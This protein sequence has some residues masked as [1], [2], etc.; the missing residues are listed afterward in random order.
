MKEAEVDRAY[1]EADGITAE[2][3]LLDAS[4]AYDKNHPAAPSLSSFEVKTMTP[5]QLKDALKRTFNITL[6]AKEL[7]YLEATYS[8][9]KLGSGLIVCQDFLNKFMAMGKQK[10]DEAHKLQLEKQRK[11]IADAKYEH[12]KK[13]QDMLEKAELKVDWDF[14][15]IDLDNAMVKVS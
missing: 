12:E 2:R 8:S 5:G 3:K 7:G 1:T 14:E 13:M 6:T 10:R 15:P 4:T 9:E 11:A